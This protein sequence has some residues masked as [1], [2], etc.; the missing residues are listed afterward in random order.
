MR[1]PPAAIL[2]GLYLA[3]AASGCGESGRPPN[4]VLIVADDLGYGDIGPFGS[5]RNRTP[6][7]DRMADEGMKLT[8]FY[9]STPYCSPSRA[10]FLTGSYHKRVSLNTVLF[11][12]ESVGLN[13][14]E[15]T[16]AEVLKDRGYATGIVGKWHLGDQKPFLPTNQGFDE[17]Y[18]LPYSN[19][20]WPENPN[21]KFPPLPLMRDHTVA[22]E[23]DDQSVLMESYTRE[24]LAFIE[25]HKDEPFF[26]Y[27][28]HTAVHRPIFPGKRFQGRSSNGAFGD[29]VEEL[30][31]STGEI[32]EALR[33]NGLDEQT[34]V[35]FTSDNGPI[36]GEEASAGPLRGRKGSSYEGGMRVP[37]LV[38]WPGR[39][40]AASSSDEIAAAMDLL[41]TLAGLADAALPG[42]RVLDGRD[43][44]PILAGEAGARSP[45]EVLQ[46]WHGA[47]LVGVRNRSW[48]LLK[49][50]DGSF[51]LYRIDQDVGETRNVAKANPEV[52]EQMR[53]HYE[54]AQAD[55]GKPSNRRRIG[56]VQKP[57][58]LIGFDHQ[59]RADARAPGVSAAALP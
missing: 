13:P 54:A 12:G 9:V 18:G 40:P 26:L 19:D 48:K 35:I 16:L 49:L 37:A 51:E 29:W 5:N 38:R 57:R 6:T 50:W 14:D 52:L 41:P 55:L 34:L 31:W 8:S 10:S 53:E 4:F 44:W 27:L 47:G 39:V 30:D 1:M 32:L 21:R 28:P 17:F 2:A 56:R 33:R 36:F 7:L 24:A 11:P 20:M 58:P 43:V 22:G 45:H 3:V 46:Y 25:A 15:V 59:V 23:V 42:D